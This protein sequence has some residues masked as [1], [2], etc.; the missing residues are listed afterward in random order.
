MFYDLGNVILLWFFLKYLIDIFN[1]CNMN[2]KILILYKS[3]KFLD[4]G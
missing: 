1:I 3:F 2:D 4:F